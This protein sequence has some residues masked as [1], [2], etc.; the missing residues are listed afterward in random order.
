M[1]FF[2]FWLISW[3]NILLPDRCWTFLVQ[4]LNVISQSVICLY[5]LL[6]RRFILVTQFITKFVVIIQLSSKT[7]L[8][9]LCINFV[10]F[11]FLR[12]AEGI[13][14]FFFFLLSSGGKDKGKQKQ[15]KVAYL[16]SYFPFYF[17]F[18]FALFYYTNHGAHSI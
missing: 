5:V 13:F 17:T 9:E 1:V 3:L 7:S 16:S 10:S 18:R 15:K 6:S 14:F 11:F 12:A 4:L 8:L 2:L